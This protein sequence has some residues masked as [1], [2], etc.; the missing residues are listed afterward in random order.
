MNYNTD[1]ILGITYE[2]IELD[3]LQVGITQVVDDEFAVHRLKLETSRHD[4]LRAMV[5]KLKGYV[6]SENLERYEIKYPKDWWEAFKE[7]W[8]PDRLL[9]KYPVKYT[10]EVIDLKALY[11]KLKVSLP[12]EHRTYRMIREKRTTR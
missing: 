10:T 3:L 12:E 2:T 4:F 6:L 5:L 1:D 8:F 11:P 9:K 7:R